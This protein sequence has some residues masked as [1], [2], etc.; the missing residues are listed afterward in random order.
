MGSRRKARDYFRNRLREERERREWSQTYLAELL[1][2]QGFSMYGTTIAKIEA[3]DRA[4]QIDE[5][6]A[7][8]DLF[9]VSLDS[10]LGRAVG[11]ENDLAFAVRIA[12]Q[13]ARRHL[14]QVGDMIEANA[15]QAEEISGF[16]FAQRDEL[17]SLIGAASEPL[18]LA[19]LALRQ[20]ERFALAVDAPVALANRTIGQQAAATIRKM[21]GPD[22]T[23]Q[24]I[25]E[26]VT[27]LVEE[28]ER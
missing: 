10:L 24:A 3:G 5:A 16:D 23:E 4:V 21:L 1:A 25:A 17:L 8:A 13:T 15:Q 20:V 22:M 19:D 18:I 26:G 6:A 11:L 9:D 2:K 7:I 12:Q 14:D 27:W 28:S